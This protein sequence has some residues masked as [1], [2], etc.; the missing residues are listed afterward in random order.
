MK[1]LKDEID[2]PIH[3]HTHDTSGINSSSIL[4]ASDAGVDIADAAIASMSGQTSQP[5][6]NSG[7]RLQAR[8]RNTGLDL[9]SLNAISDYW[10]TVREFYYPF[11]E[12]IK[13]GSAEVYLHEMPGGQYT[14]LKQQ[15]K[16]LHLADRW[17]EIA[18]MYATVNQLFGDIV[19]VTP[20]SKVV[21]DM[22]LFMVT[23]NL[24]PMDVLNPGKK[25]SFPKSV[26]EMM[27]GYLGVPQGGW[28]KVL[29]KIILDSANAK[30]FKG[31]P[32]TVTR[33]L[34][35]GSAKRAV[36]K[37]RPRAVRAGVAFVSAL[38]A[39]L[40]SVLGR[41]VKSYSNT[42][43]IPTPAFFYGLHRGDEISV[44]I[45]PGK[46]LVVKFLTVSEP[47]DDGTRAVFYELN[48]QYEKVNLVDRSLE[49]AQHRHP[50]ADA[51][52]PNHVAAP[53]PGKVSTVAVKKGDA[54]KTGQRLL[55][56]EAMK[57]ETAVYS[58]RDA[59]IADVLVKPG[60]TIQARDL[61][62]VLE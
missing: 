37:A 48:G 1:A 2:V 55:S 15:A 27:Q 45:E 34:F 62:V 26:V 8:R 35:L 58:P 53:M 49:A 36:E 44:E 28:P 18:Q 25:L 32:A 46:T 19:K 4:R 22:A 7:R 31:R 29:Q 6:L 3:F 61:L 13:S 39:G 10:E 14:N 38:S 42:S 40:S 54:V 56:I 20:S 47:H 43:V 60:S 24:S 33:C 12:N 51:E 11:E 16:S 50:K 21:G 41:H 57:M 17:Q 23:G 5:N 59:S 9:P 52:D 30:P